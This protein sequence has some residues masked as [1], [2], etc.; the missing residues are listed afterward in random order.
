MKVFAG[1]TDFLPAR[2]QALVQGIELIGAGVCVFQPVPLHHRGFEQARGCIRVVLQQFRDATIEG[3]IKAAKEARFT[4][5]PAIENKLFVA[6]GDTQQ[7]VLIETYHIL[8]RLQA[9]AM[10]FVGGGFE[11][12]DFMGSEGIAR[13][14]VPVRI[15]VDRAMKI[16]A[17]L[18]AL[19]LPV[20][21]RFRG[22][23]PH[24]PTPP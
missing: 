18:L 19:G 4:R 17:D 21:S 10:Q 12:V 8:D 7:S 3:E 14:L 23:A 9:Q 13:R 20:G 15:I 11:G 16:E 22:F 2:D 1:G 6:Y 5:L 24:S